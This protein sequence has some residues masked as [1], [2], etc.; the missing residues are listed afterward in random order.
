M[1][2]IGIIIIIIGIG[3]CYYAS[4]YEYGLEAGLEYLIN[5]KKPEG[6]DLARFF[7]SYGGLVVMVGVI[8]LGY[9]IYVSKKQGPKVKSSYSPN[10]A[11][12]RLQKNNGNMLSAHSNPGNNSTTW[13]SN[14]ETGE[15]MWK[16]G[17]C[18]TDNPQAN[19]FCS[20]CGSRR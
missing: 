1:I 12:L 5:G 3:G 10:E 20:N 2:I 9:G 16:C 17:K 15:Y 13:F 8:I 14:P 4:N 11:L 7:N 18:G 19:V 6:L